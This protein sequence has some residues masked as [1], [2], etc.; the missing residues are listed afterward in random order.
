[1][2]TLHTTMA[3]L[4]TVF[5]AAWAKQDIVK[6]PNI[7]GYMK[8]TLPPNAGHLLL[9]VNWGAM[10]AEPCL[11][12]IVKVE[13]LRAAPTADQADKVLFLNAKTGKYETYAVCSEDNEF[14][15]RDQWLRKPANPSMPRGSGFWIESAP[16]S[17]E[18]SIIMIS[19]EVVEGPL[20]K[21]NP[22]SKMKII[23]NTYPADVSV[24][25]LVEPYKPHAG[26]EV[27][28][29]TGH[30]YEMYTLGDDGRWSHVQTRK[31]PPS[32]DEG[33]AI[34]LLPA[35]RPAKKR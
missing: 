32:V 8:Y 29:F 10:G 27:A 1:M 12:D 23:A 28:F 9:G 7:V 6:S 35:E 18:P 34:W 31:A 24:Q 11:R 17:T 2:K 15:A 3:V 22:K 13:Q 4:L 25:R 16:G 21:L 26:D 19:G 14:Y 20:V 5:C 30:G 33:A